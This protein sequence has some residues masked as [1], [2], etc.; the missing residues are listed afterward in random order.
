[1]NFSADFF[2]FFGVLYIYVSYDKLILDIYKR[3]ICYKLRLYST[4]NFLVI[5][6][7]Y[8]KFNKINVKNLVVQLTHLVIFNEDIHGLNLHLAL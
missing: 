8:I 2:F 4:N 5:S 3:Y 6:Y 1:V 7:I